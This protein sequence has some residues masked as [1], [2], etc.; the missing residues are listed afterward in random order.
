LLVALLSV[1]SQVL[2]LAHL[3]LTR[4]VVCPEHGELI[5]VGDAAAHG[6]TAAPAEEKTEGS[7]RGRSESAAF[8]VHD[9][10]SVSALRREQPSLRQAPATLVNACAPAPVARVAHSVACPSLIA[11]LQL[12]P[13]G[14][15]PAFRA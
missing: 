7:Y 1:S 3:L 2:G 8:D 9:H 12:A 14:S 15:P 4:H 10:C 5:H 13:K 11:I 6:L